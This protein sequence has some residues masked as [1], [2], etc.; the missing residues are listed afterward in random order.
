MHSI[1]TTT[2][3]LRVQC[4]HVVCIDNT[5]L[6]GCISTFLGW[7]K[8]STK[9]HAVHAVGWPAPD[10]RLR[11]RVQK[12]GSSRESGRNP[13]RKGA[14]V[15]GALSYSI[16]YSTCWFSAA[17]VRPRLVQGSKTHEEVT[18]PCWG[19]HLPG[20]HHVDGGIYTRGSRTWRF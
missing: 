1:R 10:R 11:P 16:L 3:Y 8:R 18:E 7:C 6:A 12:E 15:L 9:Q 5:D 20:Y 17:L 19:G 13:A 2:D 14:I 4:I